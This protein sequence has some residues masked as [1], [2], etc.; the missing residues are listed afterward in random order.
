MVVQ[1]GS[2]T[3]LDYF[4]PSAAVVRAAVVA[5]ALACCGSAAHATLLESTLNFTGVTWSDGGGASG[6]FTYTYDSVTKAVSAV[7]SVDV[8]TTAGTALPGFAFIYNVPGQTNTISAPTVDWSDPSTNTYEV[9]IQNADVTNRMWLDWDNVGGLAQLVA[10]QPSAGNVAVEQ[11]PAN[12]GRNM[13][14]A[15]TS[16]VGNVPEPASLALLGVGAAMLGVIR[17]RRT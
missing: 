13:V 17:R 14:N 16:Q 10:S 7:T 5:L 8:T 2:A 1:T 9:Y 12:F 15:G 3:V 6:S 4:I 11:Y